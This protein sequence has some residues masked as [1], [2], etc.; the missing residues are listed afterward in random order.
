[1]DVGHGVL[2]GVL[3]PVIRVNTPF[4]DSS[5]Y[6]DYLDDHPGEHTSQAYVLKGGIKNWLAMFRDEQD[7]VDGV[8]GR[9]L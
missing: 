3:Y 7:L 5:R 8:E 9:D 1:M 2:D 6:Q 4:N